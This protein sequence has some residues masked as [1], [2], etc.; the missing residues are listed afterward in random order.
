MGI[1]QHRGG[2]DQLDNKRERGGA[3]GLTG[4]SNWPKTQRERRRDKVA[5]MVSVNSNLGEI[6]RKWR[7]RWERWNREGDGVFPPSVE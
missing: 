4:H 5:P 3:L 6:K 1:V 2:D 7:G